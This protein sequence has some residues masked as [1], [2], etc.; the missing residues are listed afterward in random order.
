[1]V[2]SYGLQTLRVFRFRI[3]HV[4]KMQKAVETIML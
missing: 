3:L 4:K 1:L 2:F